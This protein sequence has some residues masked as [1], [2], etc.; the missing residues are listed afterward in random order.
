[1]RRRS[2]LAGA[3]AGL[4]R[5]HRRRRRAAGATAALLALALLADYSFA[6]AAVPRFVY[7]FHRQR[8]ARKLSARDWRAAARAAA[9]L[10]RYNASRADVEAMPV[11]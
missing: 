11:M 2:L 10:P 9:T 4:G 1:M 3:M 5:G 8:W 6:N 7:H